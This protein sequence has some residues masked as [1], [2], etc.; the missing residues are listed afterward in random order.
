[1][2]VERGR[3]PPCQSGDVVKDGTAANGK[4]RFRC[5][6][7]TLCGRTFIREYPDQGRVPL[8][9]R[10]IVER[11]LK[12]R[13]V[14]DSA[15]VWQLSPTTV[16]EELKKKPRPCSPSTKGSLRGAALKRLR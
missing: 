8:V 14:R 5:Q 9:K 11:T 6:N 3:C 15:R 7:G 10:Q 13:G 12:G 4:D 16:I 2:A 1:M